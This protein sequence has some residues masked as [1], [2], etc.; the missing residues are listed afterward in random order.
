M[1]DFGKDFDAK[2]HCDEN[3]AK[4]SLAVA[5]MA[6]AKLLRVVPNEACT[7]VVVRMRLGK[8]VVRVEV[9]ADSPYSTEEKLLDKVLR[10]F[11]VPRPWTWSTKCSR[12]IVKEMERRGA[13]GFERARDAVYRFCD[14]KAL[15]KTR[16]DHKVQGEL[17]RARAVLKNARAAGAT[18]RQMR[19]LISQ[20]MAEE[21]VAEVQSS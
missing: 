21:A 8:K 20:I 16:K 3:A 2:K 15:E 12:D 14:S 9:D 7:R 13:L 4:L 1:W 17:N 6:N 18:P 5:F 10:K 19:K 11:G